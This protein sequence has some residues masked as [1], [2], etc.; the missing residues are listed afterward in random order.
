MPGLD[1]PVTRAPLACPA[2]CGRCLCGSRCRSPAAGQ[3]GGV[4]LCCALA[5]PGKVHIVEIVAVAALQRVVR[6]EPCPFV[7][8]QLAAFLEEFL[9]GADGAEDLAPDFLGGLHLAR[10]LVGPLVWHM[11]IRAGRTH[12][13]AVA[14]VDGVLDL[15]EHV[16]FHLVAGDAERL[17]VGGLQ[18]RV[19]TAPEDDPGDEPAKRQR[20]EAVVDARSPQDGPVAFENDLIDFIQAPQFPPV[21]GEV[22]R[23]SSSSMFLK[24]F[25]TSGFTSCCGTWHCV[26]KYRRGATAARVC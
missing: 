10:D 7:L 19:E 17:G 25:S 11:A 22:S 26:Q 14:V 5:L 20:A 9:A 24:R 6:L 12:A 8:G 13:G 21:D 3:G 1:L 15:H 2:V 23:Y 18:R 4:E 16:V